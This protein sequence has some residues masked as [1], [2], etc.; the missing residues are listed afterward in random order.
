MPRLRLLAVLGL[1]AAAVAFAHSPQPP[2][3][4]PQSTI[5]PR[6]APGEGQKFLAKFVGTWEVKK[7]FHPRAGDPVTPETLEAL[8]GRFIAE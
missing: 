3:K 2:K 7:T 6:S 1:I 5:E 8:K 4:D